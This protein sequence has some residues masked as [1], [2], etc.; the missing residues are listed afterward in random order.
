MTKSDLLDKG[1]EHI[2]VKLADDIYTPVTA[3][4][5]NALDNNEF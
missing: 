2:D 4:S 5:G 3:C 1:V